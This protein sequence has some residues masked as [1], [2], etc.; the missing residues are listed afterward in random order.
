MVLNAGR[1]SLWVLFVLAV[2][3]AG[4]QPVWA[5]HE[6]GQLDWIAGRWEGTMGESQIEE[7]WSPPAGRVMM[8][9][10][11]WLRGGKLFL[12]EFFAIE[13]SEEQIRLLL[14]H[15]SRGLVAW[16]D[17]ETPLTFQL[18][19]LEGQ[20]AVFDTRDEERPVRLTYQRE[21]EELVVV[22][23]RVE[24]GKPQRDEFHYRLVTPAS[25]R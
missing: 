23:E 25:S 12:Y 4:T 19:E 17:K 8:G 15:F 13:Q 18:V 20:K 2:T 9:M 11:R 6:I 21:G 7:N 5:G 14:R 10:L 24:G 3:A 22:L 1:K 16:E